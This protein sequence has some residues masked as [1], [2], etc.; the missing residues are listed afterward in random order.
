[1]PW[2][3]ADLDLDLMRVEPVTRYGFAD[4]SSLELSAD[5]PRALAALEALSPGT[6]ADWVRFLGTCAAM[7]GASE[8]FLTGPAPWPPRRGAADPRDALRVK[9][10]VDAP[11]SSLAPTRATR[12]CG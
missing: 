4:G 3:F 6:G 7:W 12:G 1:M 9:P 2:V 10:V 11:R 8:R 5:L